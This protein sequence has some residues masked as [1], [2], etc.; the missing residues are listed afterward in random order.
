MADKPNYIV[1]H[2]VYQKQLRVLLLPELQ[3]HLV[4]VHPR[5]YQ[6]GPSMHDFVQVSLQDEV[7]Y[8]YDLPHLA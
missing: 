5:Q 3:S 4:F 8:A 2:L 6:S 7:G 1:G